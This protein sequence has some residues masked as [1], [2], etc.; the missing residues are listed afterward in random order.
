MRYEEAQ[1]KRNLYPDFITLR[2]RVMRI[3]IVPRLTEDFKRYFDDYL[4]RDFD[5]DLVHCYSS[6]G[7]FNLYYRVLKQN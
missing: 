5:D 6:N 4:F 7:Q 1:N 2:G 3:F